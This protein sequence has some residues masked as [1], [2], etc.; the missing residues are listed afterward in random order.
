MFT[1]AIVDSG[2]YCM[3]GII[4]WKRLFSCLRRLWTTFESRHLTWDHVFFIG[5]TDILLPPSVYAATINELKKVN[6]LAINLCLAICS[7]ANFEDYVSGFS[8]TI[9]DYFW[10]NILQH[11]PPV[12][13][14][15]W[16]NYCVD[17]DPYQ[18]PYITIYLTD[19]SEWH[20]IVTSLI[21]HTRPFS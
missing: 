14:R 20:C 2:E 3:L 5:T 7:S 6:D 17:T 4:F 15:F 1:N 16:D 18:W 8:T 21:C 19:M 13:E 12:D 9:F 11:A 10:L